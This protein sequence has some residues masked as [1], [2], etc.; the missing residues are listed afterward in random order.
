MVKAAMKQKSA[1]AAANGAP[2]REVLLAL[3]REIKWGQA[4]TAIVP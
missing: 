4:A 2:E 1:K 3:K